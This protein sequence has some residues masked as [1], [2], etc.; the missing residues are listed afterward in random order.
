[1]DAYTDFVAD[2]AAELDRIDNDVEALSDT[3]E[4]LKESV[5]DLTARVT[6]QEDAFEPELS[7]I[8]ARISKLEAYIDTTATRSAGPGRK[9]RRIEPSNIA[10]LGQ[11]SA[12][13]FKNID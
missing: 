6:E 5:E 1:M 9:K 7:E 2:L 4:K 8:K 3:V 10:P 12:K 13:P 11:Y